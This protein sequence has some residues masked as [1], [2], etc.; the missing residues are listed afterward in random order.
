MLKRYTKDNIQLLLRKLGERADNIPQKVLETVNGVIAAV[1]KDG[2]AALK[3]FT[4][5]FDG[6][7]LDSLYLT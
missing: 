2:D 6:V 7:A 1:R 3:K 4:L 5:D